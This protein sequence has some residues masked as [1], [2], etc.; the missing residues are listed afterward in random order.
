MFFEKKEDMWNLNDTKY[1]VLP[2]DIV[3]R[4][5]DATNICVAGSR[6]YYTFS[7]SI[8]L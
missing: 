8:F 4:K 2:S 7:V 5:I 1:A 3:R 6:L